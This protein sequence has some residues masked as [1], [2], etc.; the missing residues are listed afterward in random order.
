M[1]KKLLT[2]SLMSLLLSCS[3]DKSDTAGGGLKV[4]DIDGDGFNSVDD[5]DDSDPFTFPGAAELED[6]DACMTDADDDGFG[7]SAP[8]DGVTAGIDCDDGNAALNAADTDGD[9]FSTCDL[10]CDDSD[11]NTFPGAAEFD[12]PEACMTASF[13]E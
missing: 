3:A 2:I 13:V 7:E 6:A 1:S 12:D 9:G 11:I 8:S 5:C 4:V 10:D